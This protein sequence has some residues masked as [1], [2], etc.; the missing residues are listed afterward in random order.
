MITAT[1]PPF[2]FTK[3]PAVKQVMANQQSRH[4]REGWH[5]VSFLLYKY[6]TRKWDSRLRG[7]DSSNDGFHKIDGCLEP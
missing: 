1:L 5:P 4:S 3:Q 2:K 6:N 7:N